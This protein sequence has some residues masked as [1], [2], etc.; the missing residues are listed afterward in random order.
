[1]AWSGLVWLSLAWLGLDSAGKGLPSFTMSM[2]DDLS[3]CLILTTV[4]ASRRLLR[5]GDAKFRPY[6]VT[7]QQFSLLAAVRFYPGEPVTVLA[8]RILLDRT[9]L[10]RNLDL[11][12][13]KELVRRVSSETGNAR[14]CELT[15]SGDLL[16]DQLMIEWQQSQTALIKDFSSQD[17]ETYLRV[18]RH[19]TSE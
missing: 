17:T 18:A 4:A 1:M 16:L 15:K 11:L 12:E 6:G 7:V 10:T 8:S 14:L 9:S 13:R 5:H 19:L 2:P 3:N